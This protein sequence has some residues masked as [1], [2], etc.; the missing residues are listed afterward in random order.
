MVSSH[1]VARV[2][3]VGKYR[4][5]AIW[6]GHLATPERRGREPTAGALDGHEPFLVYLRRPGLYA[7]PVRAA[8]LP[9]DVHCGTSLPAAAQRYGHRARSLHVRCSV[10]HGSAPVLGRGGG[11]G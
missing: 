7:T 2:V 6:F 5:R 8:S 10:E 11:A 4:P 9:V 3:A 1:L